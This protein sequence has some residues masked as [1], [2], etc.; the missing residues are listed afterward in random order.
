MSER[1]FANGIDVESDLEQPPVIEEVT[2]V[3]NK[4]GFFHIVVDFLEVQIAVLG[5]LGEKGQGVRPF[6]SFIWVFNIFNLFVN[7]IEIL[8]RVGQGVRVG[9]AQMRL[10]FKQTLTDIN[11]RSIAS[12]PRVGLKR[13]P[14]HS[15]F[16][17]HQRPEHGLKNLANEPVHLIVVD[18]NH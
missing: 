2:S 1:R 12:I 7:A 9:N 4:G 18:G 14:E 3:K 13:K 15:N 17:I 6:C 10:F 16:F 8:L 5:P 11:R